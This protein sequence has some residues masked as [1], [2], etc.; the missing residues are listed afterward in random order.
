VNDRDYKRNVVWLREQDL[1]FEYKRL[2]GNLRWH[3]AR[4]ED[5]KLYQKQLTGP[6]NG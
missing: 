3:V 4:R 1:R 2:R 6:Q 5:I